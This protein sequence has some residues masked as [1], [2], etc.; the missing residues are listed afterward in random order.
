MGWMLGIMLDSQ[1]ETAATG[2]YYMPI[3]NPRANWSV[4]ATIQ[5]KQRKNNN[6]N[7][8]ALLK[9]SPLKGA[10]AHGVSSFPK[11]FVFASLCSFICLQAVYQLS[12]PED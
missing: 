7:W 11:Y 9:G 1:V 2:L 5:A 12:G 3:Y 10:L 4:D 6:N 8:R